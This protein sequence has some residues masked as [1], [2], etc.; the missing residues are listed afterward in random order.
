MEK[1]KIYREYCYDLNYNFY[2]NT[3]KALIPITRKEYRKKTG[4][5]DYIINKLHDSRYP[6][7]LNDYFFIKRADGVDVPVDYLLFDLI[8]YFNKIGFTT[9]YVHQGNVYHIGFNYSEDIMYFFEKNLG[10]ESITVIYIEHDFK[11]GGNFNISNYWDEARYSGKFIIVKR[12]NINFDGSKLKT[13]DLYFDNFLLNLIYQKFGVKKRSNSE[14][15][16]ISHK[17]GRIIRPIHI[18]AMKDLIKK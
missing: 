15:K 4:E 5:S 17:G 10:P 9:N 2:H 8:S 7:Q 16:E 12:I 6:Y 14:L 1:L 11:K 3:G 13:I 18:N